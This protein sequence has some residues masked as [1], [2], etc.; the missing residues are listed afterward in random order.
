MEEGYVAIDSHNFAVCSST[1]LFAFSNQHLLATPTH[2]N[3]PD[4]FHYNACSHMQE[5]C[6]CTTCLPV[7]RI[8]QFGVW[9]GY[10]EQHDIHQCSENTERNYED[11]SR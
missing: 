11:D 1:L 8:I 6:G 5:I 10:H 4:T 7:M 2:F 9:L 3:T